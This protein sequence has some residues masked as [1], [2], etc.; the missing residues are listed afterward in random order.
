MGIHAIEEGQGCGTT[1]HP[2]ADIVVTIIGMVV[3]AVRGARIVLIVVERPATHNPRVHTGDPNQRQ[4]RFSQKIIPRDSK[5]I[6]SAYGVQ[7][8]GGICPLITP[9]CPEFREMGDDTPPE[10]RD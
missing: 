9:Q 3:V 7:S 8:L 1:H 4:C 2:K 10:S 6:D 5:K